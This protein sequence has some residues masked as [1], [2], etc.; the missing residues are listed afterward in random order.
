M[1]ALKI[2]VSGI[3]GLSF[4]F[5]V[6]Y[7]ASYAAEGVDLTTSPLPISLSVLPGNSVTTDVRVK[8]EGATTQQLKVS[9]MKFTAYGESGKPA[10][11]D[12][13]PG[14]DYF[15]WV[16]FSPSSFS[17]PPGQWQTIK[18]TISTPKT[19][20]FGYYYAVVFTPQ[21]AKP[22]GRG[23]VLIGSTAVLVL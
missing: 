5:M 20:A 2:V 16:S 18:M 9:L 4:W 6:F 10:L 14:D 11:K 23:N 15:D 3:L 1:R 17:A 21:T 22:T 7:P 13:E 12:R 8:N 19:A